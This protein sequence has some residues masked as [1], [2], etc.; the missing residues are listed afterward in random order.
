MTLDHPSVI[1]QLDVSGAYEQDGTTSPDAPKPIVVITDLSI[2]IGDSTVPIDMQGYRL[3]AL[4]DGTHD[5]LV[6]DAQGG[7]TYTQNVNYIHL[8]E[9]VSW[10]K[11]SSFTGMYYTADNRDVES[12][13]LPATRNVSISSL[14]ESQQVIHANFV[15]QRIKIATG[16]QAG[17]S[18]PLI[19]VRDER[20]TTIADF[21]EYI[22]SHPF[23]FYWER[24]YPQTVQLGRIVLPSAEN[25]D[26]V[27][28]QA[29]VNTDVSIEYDKYVVYKGAQPVKRI[30]KGTTQVL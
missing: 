15:D 12:T 30:Y 20:F 11:G 28:A 26:A 10:A 4:P 7:V 1:T 6:I 29:A 2:R 17:F 25:G 3:A 27:Y 9:T 8:D 18:N 5:E 13:A 16:S 14:Y 19:I 21:L 23:D 22:Y 24:R